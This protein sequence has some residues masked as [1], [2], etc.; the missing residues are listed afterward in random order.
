[1]RLK[2]LMATAA[3]A[4]ASPA[5]AAAQQPP[6][7]PFVAYSQPVIALTHVKLVD[8]TGAPAR[9]DMTVVIKD[10]RFLAVGASK[11]TAPPPGA[12]V[13]DG[14]GKTVIPGL[15]F[16]HEHMFYPAG[17]LNFSEMLASFP[18]LYLAGGVTT[19]RTAGTLNGY[20]DLNLRDAIAAGAVVGPDLDVTA[21]Y[22]EG[23]GLPV[24]KIHG[25]KD[26]DEA[27]QF[28]DYWAGQGA[29]SF[30]AYILISRAELKRAIDAAH[31]HGAKI[32]GHLCSVTYR[33]AA[34]MGIDNLEHGLGVMSDFIPGKQEDTCAFDKLGDLSNVDPD[35]AEVKSL[36]RLLIDRKVALTSTLV[37]FEDS[38]PHHPRL[39][40]QARSVLLPEARKMYD[41]N[42]DAIDRA[43]GAATEGFAKI[44]KMEKMFAD[45]GG[46]LMAGSDPTGVGG[47]V[48]GFASKRQLELLVEEGFS[49]EQ[50]VR[51]GSLNGAVF[52]GRD[53]DIGSVAPG[54]RA[55]LVLIDGDP[56]AHA[57]D[58]EKIRL[59]FKAGVAYDPDKMIASVRD[60]VGLR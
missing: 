42:Q 19:A 5:L 35:S 51:I 43:A 3:L 53:K 28:V 12:T 27:Q 46:L 9:P 10:G 58:V 41:D 57:A 15:V 16:M 34:E 52:M 44:K 17:E 54:K 29:T 59:V 14:T 39:N 6:A 22:L 31:A 1:M 4:L 55:D 60:L 32:T 2:T 37:T 56:A 24:Y 11:K 13:I 36:I 23:K 40:Q 25:L 33:E 50:A 45:Q 30:K 48:P 7:N 47:A 8:G 26:A 18:T 49:F 21:P 20:A 38:V